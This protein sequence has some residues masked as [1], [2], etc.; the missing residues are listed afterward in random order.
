MAERVPP[1]VLAAGE[2]AVERE[3][4]AGTAGAAGIPG[5]E[6]A[7]RIRTVVVYSILV[8]IAVLFAIPFLWSVS[9]SFRT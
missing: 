8:V 5:R 2:L 7:D 1:P 3:P 6:R 9:T 4:A